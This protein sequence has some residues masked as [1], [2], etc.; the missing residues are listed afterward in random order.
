MASGVV[1]TEAKAL[2]EASMGVTT[3]T[4]VATPK[5]AIMSVTGSGSTG[6]TEFTGGSYARQTL[7]AGSATTAVPSV[8]ANTGVI[9]FTGMPALTANGI[10]IFDTTTSTRRLWWGDLTTPKVLGSGDTL[11][12]AI[13]TITIS[14]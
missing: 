5:V 2:L 10:A 12:F 1:Q 14:M 13:G 11:S 9:T 7:G 3:Y 8:I 6:G 4:A